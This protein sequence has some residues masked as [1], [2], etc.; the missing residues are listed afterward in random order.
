MVVSDELHHTLWVKIKV[1]QKYE[2]DRSHPLRH[3]VHIGGGLRHGGGELQ[4]TLRGGVRNLRCRD[5]APVQ[6]TGA[7]NSF[8]HLGFNHRVKTP[9]VS[10]TLTAMRS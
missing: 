3:S 10:A 1:L 7:L 6:R 2:G 9:F 5:G 4:S 8:G